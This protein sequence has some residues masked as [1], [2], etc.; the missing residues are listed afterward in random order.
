[1]PK[2]LRHLGKEFK[3]ESPQPA[4]M[5]KWVSDAELSNPQLAIARA[6]AEIAEKEVARNRGGHYPTVDLVANYSSNK[7]NGGSFG[8]G[9]DTTN[10]SI[11]VQLNMPLFRAE[12]SIQ[13]GVKRK[14]I[15]NEQ[16]V[17]WRMP[18]AASPCKL[19][20]VISA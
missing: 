19:A 1:M 7:A 13:N 12:R 18:A 4:D 6:A 16:G 8:V 2:D 9:S 20:R 11:G 5:E 17:N 3:L 14:L 15:L 10:K